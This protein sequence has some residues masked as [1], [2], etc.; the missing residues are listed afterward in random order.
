M[1]FTLLGGIYSSGS[2]AAAAFRSRNDI[3]NH[4]FGG[5]LTG[6][7]V[8]ASARSVNSVVLYTFGCGVLGL[9]SYYL[10]DSVEES[11]TYNGKNPSRKYGYLSKPENA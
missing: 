9:V 11:D 8:G 2:C 7:F 6:A 3:Y 1:Y 4:G 10:V 5:A